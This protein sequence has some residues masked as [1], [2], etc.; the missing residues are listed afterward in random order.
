MPRTI[1]RLKA[2]VGGGGGVRKRRK[3]E[4]ILSLFFPPLQR[5]E[6]RVK[7]KIV[8]PCPVMIIESDSLNNVL[9]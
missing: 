8:V 3:G 2:S 9:L 4:G 6:V 1:M 7:K 5:L